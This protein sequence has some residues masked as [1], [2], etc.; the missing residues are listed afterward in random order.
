MYYY[1]RLWCVRVTSVA[2]ETQQDVPFKL[3]F[4]YV[5][6]STIQKC[7]HGN[8]KL[9]SLGAAVELQ[10]I[11]YCC[12]QYKCAKFSCKVPNTFVLF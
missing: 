1:I 5:L 12:Q 3:L 4:T 8:A 6:L 7:Y 10:N 2:M 11:L 9:G